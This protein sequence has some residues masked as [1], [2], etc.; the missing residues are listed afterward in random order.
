MS[1][2]RRAVPVF[3]VRPLATTRP[4]PRT[5]RF[6]AQADL[7]S[8]GVD[9]TVVSYGTEDPVD[10]RFNSAEKRL[11]RV[12]LLLA[13]YGEQDLPRR[14]N[15]KVSQE[16][17]AKMVGTTRSRVNFFMNRFKKLGFITL[18][19]GLTI[20]GPLLSVVLHD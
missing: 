3:V 19:G 15:P 8:A 10:Q 9:R 2:N 1:T 20:N 17:L 6:N 11:A 7:D 12:L 4:T 16:T 5:P 18:D 14:A 13:R